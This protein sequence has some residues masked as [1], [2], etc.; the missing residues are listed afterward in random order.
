MP[1]RNAILATV[2]LALLI[3]VGWSGYRQT[4]AQA[5]SQRTP[6]PAAQH[7]PVTP[8]ARGADRAAVRAAVEAFVKAF[9]A[10]DPKALAALWT[11]EGEYKNERG[12][13]V[14]GRE[15]L[16]KGFAAFFARTPE[17]KAEV[18]PG[19]TRFLSRDTAT[20]DGTVTV[21]RGPASSATRARYHAL[22]VRE[23]GRWKFARLEESAEE[24][25]SVDDLAFLVGEWTST[26]GQG[27]EIHTTYSW[28]AN[29][30]F[31]HVQFSI[32]EKQLTLS[33]DQ[34]IGVDPA[35][36]ALHTWT[37]E[38]DGGVGEADWERDGDHWVLDATGTLADGR[39]L[40]ETNVLRRVNDDR[41]TWQSVNRT[42]DD[43]ELPDLAPV[44][45]TR[46]RPVK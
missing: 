5:G 29:K 44:K 26:S 23:D 36:H 21:R 20:E 37:F 1:H 42:L 39:T 46:V 45:V 18:R 19:A 35:T 40:K 38:A 30:K 11:D 8:A 32:K 2:P 25:A 43:E 7:A 15:A 9:E 14:Q 6:G 28:A 10:R 41:L 22:L 13:T 31:L 3:S 33:G 24:E 34:V 4:F 17:I 12:L 16:E 27:A